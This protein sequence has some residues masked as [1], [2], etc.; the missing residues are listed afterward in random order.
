MGEVTTK[1]IEENSS[2]K[3]ITLKHCEIVTN[4]DKLNVDLQA[5][6]MN[7]TTIK[8]WAYIIHDQDDTRA[9][10][11]IYLY[12]DYPVDMHKVAKW[13]EIPINFIQKI[14][15]SR[16]DYLA[17]LIHA[18][19][20]SQ[21]KHQYKPEEVHANFDWAFE[22]KQREIIGDFE[23]YSYS[24]QIKFVESIKDAKER[25]RASKLLETVWKQHCK[26]LSLENKR[27]MQ[28][29]FITGTAGAGKTTYSKKLCSQL[30][31]DYYISSASND[32]FGDYKGQPAIIAD[33][34]RDT[35]FDKLDELLK[36]IDNNTNST[37]KSRF[38]NVVLCCK[39][40]IIT[41]SVPLTY[42]Y[43]NYKM[44]KNDSLKQ[45]YRRIGTY[46]E[47][48]KTDIAVYSEIDENGK[49]TGKRKLYKNDLEFEKK[50]ENEKIDIISVFDKMLETTERKF[51][52]LEEVEQDKLPF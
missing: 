16:Q 12:F 34:L 47:V 40:F 38:V 3:P 13:F 6:F 10:Y 46:V 14:K 8:Q 36:I 27:D 15:G 48:K 26:F 41:S 28:V 50:E 44:N 49:P 17:Y 33:D 18:N 30:N 32:M 4:V 23:H 21:Y 25:S 22:V 5:T 7:Y 51:E 52:D 24:A 43:P 39:L 42:W 45:L 31:F 9:H 35:S 2:G 29:I 20:S 11:H 1:P 37:V 19:A